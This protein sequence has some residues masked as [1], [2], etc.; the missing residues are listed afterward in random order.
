[1]PIETGSNAALQRILLSELITELREQEARDPSAT[2]V[3]DRA[4]V[5]IGHLR[6]HCEAMRD[7]D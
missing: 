5:E 1:M 7:A 6:R 2:L 4:E 3:I